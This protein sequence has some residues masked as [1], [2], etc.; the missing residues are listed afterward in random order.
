M[1]YT[2]IKPVSWLRVRGTYDGQSLRFNEFNDRG[3]L[4]G[5]YDLRVYHNSTPTRA[6][7]TMV[8]YKGKT[9]DVEL[10]FE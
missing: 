2:K 5:S 4:T 7:G 1:R 8:N 3:D 10:T 9:Y 6:F